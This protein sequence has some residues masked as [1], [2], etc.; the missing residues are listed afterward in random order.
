M[1]KD[2]YKR[3]IFNQG[4]QSNAKRP[5]KGADIQQVVNLTFQEAAFGAS[6]EIQVRREVECHVC[7]GSKAEEGS[8]NQ[9][10]PDLSL[11]HISLPFMEMMWQTQ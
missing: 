4:Y 7:H 9:T 11:I 6:K 1:K 2:V 5:V 10:C 8:E 3:Q